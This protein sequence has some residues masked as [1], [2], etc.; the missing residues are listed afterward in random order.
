MESSSRIFFNHGINVRKRSY[1]CISRVNVSHIKIASVK[2]DGA[3]SN[4]AM[5]KSLGCNSSPTDM[6]ASFFGA[7]RTKIFLFLDA[8]HMLKLIRNSLW[9]IGTLYMDN[10]TISLQYIKNKLL[11]YIRT[12]AFLEINLRSVI[13]FHK[14]K[15]K[16]NAQF[17]SNSV[18]DA[19][20]LCNKKLNLSQF[21][22]KE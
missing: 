6:T 9:E 2:F 8:Y 13:F 12:N 11:E 1:K 4:I 21:A 17:L 18:A 5:V 7:E 14:N 20:E 19:I 10:Q 3:Y 22:G 15:I 16:V